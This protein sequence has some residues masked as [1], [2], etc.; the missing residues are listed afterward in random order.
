MARQLQIDYAG[1]AA[2]GRRLVQRLEAT[3]ATVR[4]EPPPP[5]QGDGTGQSPIEV[6]IVVEG[7]EAEVRHAISRFREYYPKGRVR[8]TE[9]DVA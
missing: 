5:L 3:G 9:R 7:D 8:L 4:W 1:A 6:S 2:F